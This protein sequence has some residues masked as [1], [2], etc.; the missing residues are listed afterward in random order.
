MLMEAGFVTL[1]SGVLL[2]YSNSY[3]KIFMGHISFMAVIEPLWPIRTVLM[4]HE[5]LCIQTELM[6]T[7]H[8]K[9]NTKV[10]K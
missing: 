3:A 5:M 6:S 10:K 4:T 7:V 1:N 8:Q 9:M 2:Y